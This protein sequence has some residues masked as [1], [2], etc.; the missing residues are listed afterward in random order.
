M[1]ATGNSEGNDFHTLA[2]LWELACVLATHDMAPQAITALEE[3]KRI[4]CCAH[5]LLAEVCVVAAPSATNRIDRKLW[6]RRLARAEQCAYTAEKAD[7]ALLSVSKGER[8]AKN[9]QILEV[10]CAAVALCAESAKRTREDDEVERKGDDGEGGEAA[11]EAPAFQAYFL[12][13]LRAHLV[14]LHAASLAAK[15]PEN[16]EPLGGFLQSVQ[17]VQQRFPE[18]FDEAFQLWLIE[19]WCHAFTTSFY[20]ESGSDTGSRIEAASQYFRNLSDWTPASRELHVHHLVISGLYFLRTGE[21]KKMASVVDEIS[22]LRDAPAAQHSGLLQDAYLSSILDGLKLHAMARSD[23]CEALAFSTHAIH[24]VQ[25]NVQ[26]YAA[27][28]NKSVHVLLVAVLFDML[29]A[30]CHLLGQQCR[31]AEFGLGLAQMLQIFATHKSALEPTVVYGYFVARCHLLI[32]KY[33]VAIGRV[34]ETVIN[35]NYVIE[36]LLPPIAASTTTYPD[37]YLPL[38]V[39]AL[40][41]LTYCGSAADPAFTPGANGAPVVQE[42]CPNVVLLEFSARIL[43]M[44]GLRGLVYSSCSVELRGKYDLA[45]AKWL[46]GSQVVAAGPSSRSN[47]IDLGEHA[48]LERLRPNL[49]PLLRE[50]L[51]RMGD[52][53]GCSE[54]IAELLALFG[55]VLVELGRTA[56]GEETLKNAVRVSLHAKNLLL[57]S[58]LLAAVFRLYRSQQQ[59]ALQATTVEKYEKKLKL[60]QKRIALAQAETARN[61][62]LLRWRGGEPASAARTEAVAPQP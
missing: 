34:K 4:I 12:A 29:A 47:P 24:R 48:A 5:V 32:A 51:E 42:L 15:Y 7:A 36:K 18:H 9:R 39:D 43:E 44:E 46:W 25:A 38:W 30:H 23:P 20:N 59:A 16:T 41:V 17:F 31:Y 3:S 21:V 11:A 60:L 6:R 62:L 28:A 35:V 54:T 56:E 37:A 2:Q 57:Q 22:A 58:R 53:V 61:K 45:L 10:L 19:L 50:A 55:P 8:A 14:K 26:Q 40:D 49:L 33:A 1:A 27:A 52:H 13:K